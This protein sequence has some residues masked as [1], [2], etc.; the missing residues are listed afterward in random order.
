MHQ[1]Q[2]PTVR[3]RVPAVLTVTQTRTLL[4]QMQGEPAVVARVLY[5]CG[6]RL[7]EALQLRIKDVDFDRHVI[8]ARSGKGG[9]DRVVMLP[10]SLVPDLRTQLGRSRAWWE[11]IAGRSAQGGDAGCTR[12]Q[13]A[14][15]T[16][17][18]PQDV[19][20][21]SGSAG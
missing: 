10:R 16:V 17:A 3:K 5:G 15:G 7:M 21:Q 8:V 18:S 11:Q 2:R 4:D 12:P 9:K 13:I 19:M 6:L 20:A 14:G 1:I